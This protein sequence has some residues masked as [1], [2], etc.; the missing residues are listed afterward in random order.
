M[1][2]CANFLIFRTMHERDIK[3]LETMMPNATSDT[4]NTIKTLQPGICMTFGSAFKVPISVK[5]PMPNPAPLSSNAKINV[6]WY[7]GFNQDLTNNAIN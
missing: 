2:Q 6:V 3:Y 5:M 4:I 7:Q 1:S